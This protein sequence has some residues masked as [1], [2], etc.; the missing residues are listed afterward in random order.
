MGAAE[1]IREVVSSLVPYTVNLHIKDFIIRRAS[2]KMGFLIEGVPAGKGMLNIE[3]LIDQV[4][5]HGKCVSAILELWTPPEKELEKTLIKE[6]QWANE[7]IQYLKNIF[8][9]EN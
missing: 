6:S 9:S 2:H 7:S 4:K 5:H 1:G 3:W 8:T